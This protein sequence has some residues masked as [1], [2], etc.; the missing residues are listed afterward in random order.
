[1]TEGLSLQQVTKSYGQQTLFGPI[2][3]EFSGPGMFGIVGPNGAGKSTFLKMCAG[4]T[5]PT[6]G[7]LT[8]TWKGESQ[9]DRQWVQARSMLTGPY[10]E[11]ILELTAKEQ[12]D[13]H[14]S[15]RRPGQINWVK[16]ALA[17]SG[18]ESHL[19]RPLQYFSSGMLQKMKLI[20]ALVSEASFV[21][22]DEPTANLDQAG[23]DFFHRLL[24]HTAD[25]RLIFIAS[26]HQ[27]NDLQYCT[28]WYVPTLGKFEKT[29]PS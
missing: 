24:L 9:T 2:D 5:A 28:Q 23:V 18:L 10:V 29:T 14:F 13:F 27:V 7:T 19:N 12:L 25:E 1:M 26:N 15:L 6:S 4:Y 8:W 22:L 21:F 11:P 3:A 16:D 20:L 17:W